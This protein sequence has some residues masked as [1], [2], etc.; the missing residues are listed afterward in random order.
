VSAEAGQISFGRSSPV[1][2]FPLPLHSVLKIPFRVFSSINEYFQDPII[3]IGN[4]E[5]L[6][7]PV[8]HLSAGVLRGTADF[9]VACDGGF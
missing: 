3:A 6:R 4:P 2:I 5:R 7:S 1:Q 8:L 9:A